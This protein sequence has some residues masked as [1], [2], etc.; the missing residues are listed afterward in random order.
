MLDRAG[1]HVTVIDWNP[2]AFSRLPDEYNGETIVGN[3]VDHDMLRRSGLA[4]ANAFVAATGG[5]NR[6]VVAS[7]IAKA[8]FQVPRVIARIK[9]PDRA[10]YFNQLGMRVD[11]RTEAGARVLLELAEGVLSEQAV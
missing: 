6:N 11:C 2:S 10:C 7:Q 1:Y 8:V 5:D 4:D 3:G 9:D